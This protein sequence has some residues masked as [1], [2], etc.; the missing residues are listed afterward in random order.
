MQ[1][2]SDAARVRRLLVPLRPRDG[3]SCGPQGTLM[4]CLTPPPRL[5]TDWCGVRVCAAA[6][7]KQTTEIAE[8]K[9]QLAKRDAPKGIL[10]FFD[11]MVESHTPKVPPAPYT[12]HPSPLHPTPYTRLPYILHPSPL[13]PALF[14]RLP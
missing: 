7:L 3:V 9:A 6:T 10:G 4:A 8:L 5:E 2:L 1:G 12:L 14:T 13:H 11:R